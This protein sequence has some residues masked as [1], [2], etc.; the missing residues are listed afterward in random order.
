MK[1]FDSFS[2]R[3]FHTSIISTFGVDFPAYESIVLPRLREAGCNNNILIADGRMLAQALGEENHRPMQ[4]GRSYSV[5]AAQSQ[6]VF[7]P[8]LILQLG[9]SDGRL[10]VASAN[11]TASGLAGN[12]EVVGE[13]TISSEN[14]QSATILRQAL[15]YLS[16][17]LDSTAIAKSQISWALKR[18]PWLNEGSSDSTP[19]NLGNGERLAFIA[20]NDSRGIGARFTDLVGSRTISRLV[21]ISPYWDP[22]LGALYSLDA[23]LKPKQLT[24]LIQ[25]QSALFPTHAWSAME[26]AALY[27][28]KDVRSSSAKRFAHAKLLIAESPDGDCILFGSANCTE[29]ALGRNG[30]SGQND[31][32]CLFRE[33]PSGQ[34]LQLLGL[35]EGLAKANPINPAELPPY[36]AVD[37]IPLDDLQSKLPGRFELAGNLLKWWPS[38]SV[39][40]EGAI[41]QLFG[42]NAAPL[43][44]E[45]VPLNLAG[46]CAHFRF[47]G[48]STPCFAQ[49]HGVGF[50]SSL[51]TVDIALAI[52]ALQR[53]SIPKAIANAFERLDDEESSEGLWILEVI[54][55]VAVAEHQMGATATENKNYSKSAN[56]AA[57]KEAVQHLS[58]QQF[59]AGRTESAA[60]LYPSS[61]QLSSSHQESVRNFL[62]ALIGKGT[63]GTVFVEQ[64]Q[65]E[66]DLGMG[67]NDLEGQDLPSQDGEPLTPA[68]SPKTQPNTAQQAQKKKQ[69]NV[70]DTQRDI[71]TGV[72]NF[73]KSMK[74]EAANRHLGVVDL[75]KL[76]AFL[77]VILRAGSNLADVTKLDSRAKLTKFQVLPCEGDDN[78]RL[79]VGRVLFTF[80]RKHG[81]A[82][83]PLISKLLIEAETELGIPEDV[84][85]C[86]AT[87]FWALCATRVALNAKGGKFPI[88]PQEDKICKDMYLFANLFQT[89]AVGETIR[90]TFDGLS[91]RYAKRINVLPDA[92]LEEHLR[93]A[94]ES[95]KQL[96]V[97]PV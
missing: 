90:S 31:E 39:Q 1:L 28:L 76:R 46:N 80:F 19:V 84:L 6:G 69:Q 36:T 43:D 67:D 63:A 3:G 57:N 21:S 16:K 15:D 14:L 70:L 50:Q 32:A 77:M 27:D 66:V 79:L 62:N 91:S 23:T 11:M 60:A 10:L 59:I 20:Q 73:L 37:E 85:E 55:R 7:H 89:E 74:T 65:E 75:L 61:S 58:Y 94:E 26:H 4:A 2:A 9:K 45:L 48:T 51:A 17:F 95:R 93:Q 24:A 42:Q 71:V 72:E 82:S 25:P 96:A 44:A 35:D 87:C 8:K 97:S 41:I 5:V 13:V 34:A 29:A 49:V 68:S 47:E 12:L 33:V 81:G 38:D 78:W 22:K 83:E 52:Q 88:T 40:A 56:S 92:V 86:W 18:T 30:A 53:R 54:Q 64:Q